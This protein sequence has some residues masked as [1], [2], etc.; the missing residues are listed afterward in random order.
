MIALFYEI[1]KWFYENASSPIHLE[2]LE[3]WQILYLSI[4]VRVLICIPIAIKMFRW[5][6]ENKP[7]LVSKSFE[8][9]DMNQVY[10]IAITGILFVVT[11]IVI[12]LLALAVYCYE[13]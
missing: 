10:I 1:L 13:T 3:P 8:G 12:L 7:N 2:T 11:E 9:L 5:L 6:K 4:I